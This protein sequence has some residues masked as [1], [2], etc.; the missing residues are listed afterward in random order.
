MKKNYA[1]VFLVMLTFFVISFLTNIIGPLIPEI[2]EDFS[3]SLTMVSLLPF[4]FFIAYGLM[5]VP[6]G[7]FIEK[8]GEKATMITAFAIAFVG[9]LLFGLFPFY[10]M[11]IISLFLIGTGMA[12]LQV[13]INPLLRVA[14]GEE[15]LAYFSTM[16]QL[17]FGLASFLSPLAYSFVVVNLPAMDGDNA[18]RQIMRV[19]VPE[20]LTWIT[21]YWVFA[22]ISL[23]MVI[24]IACFRFPKVEWKE[25][26]K[27]GALAA[28][29]RLLKSPA[30]ISFFLAVFFYVGSEQGVANWMSKYLAQYYGYDPQ[31]TGARAVSWFWGLMT[32][33]TLFGLVLVKIIESRKLL[34]AFTLAA[35]ISLTLSIF[36]TAEIALYS[37]PLIGF[38][39]SVMWPIILSLALNSV[40][41]QHGTLSGI[42]ITAIA[43]GA[44][45]PLIIGWLGD[46]FSLQTGMCFLYI[47]FSYVLSVGV[48]AKP[49]VQNK[50]FA[51]MGKRNKDK[52]AIAGKNG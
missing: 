41:E 4:S 47:S 18:L 32:I 1:H 26:E 12:M 50:T 9:A 2:I 23:L 8:Y 7:I 38:F 39:A 46:L 14:G 40:R 28:H 11:A 52:V 31:V 6:S 34:M 43:G 13:V 33:G 51:F 35:M 27:A 19:L 30:V 16:G 49:R 37:F 20:N 5:S 24:V 29:M 17:F 44:I 15:N 3:L 48:W 36:G 45:I 25:D 21:L 10:L 42:L 22:I